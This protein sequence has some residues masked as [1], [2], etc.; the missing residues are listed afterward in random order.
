VNQSVYLRR[1]LS[2][3]GCIDYKPVITHTDPNIKL[4]DA[5]EPPEAV[6]F[7]YLATVGSLFFAQT[8][9]RLDI[10][11]VVSLVAQ[12]SSNPQRSHFQ[13][14]SHIFR[15]SIETVDLSLCYNDHGGD[16]ILEAYADAAYA[17]DVTDRKS[18]SGSLLIF[19]KTLVA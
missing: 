7:E 9:S 13:V 4:D 3:F 11:F 10:S 8:L 2:K 18:R 19:N 16:N 5:Q 1:I 17:G 12:F 14:V 6:K 15:Y